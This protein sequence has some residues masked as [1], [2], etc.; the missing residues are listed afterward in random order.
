M[1]VTHIIEGFAAFG[2]VAV[3]MLAIW[4]DWVRSILAPL[5]LTIIEHN[6]SG[7]PTTFH[8]SRGPAGERENSLDRI[9]RPSLGEAV[10]GDQ[11]FEQARQRSE[12]HHGRSLG[13]GGVVRILMRFD[14]N[15]GNADRRCGA[16]KHGGEF[17]LASRS[18]P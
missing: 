13:A 3:A 15:G 5:K 18:V 10:K 6:F 7:D 4:G 11:G 16:R 2:T 14:E 12:R 8:P 9:H 17:A 1:V